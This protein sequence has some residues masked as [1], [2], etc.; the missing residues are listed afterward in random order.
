MVTYLGSLVQLYC[1]EGGTLQTNAADV[2]GMLAVYGPH[3]VCPSSRSRVLPESTLLRLQGAL[4]GHC[5]KWVL[6]FVHF[7]GLSRSG[8]WVLRK[9]TDLVGHVFCALPRSEQLK[10]PGAW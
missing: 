4:Q 8:S 1:G 6:H 9:G 10:R 3:W 5:L 2:W 7:Q